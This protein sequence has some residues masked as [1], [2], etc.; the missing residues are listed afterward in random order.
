[1]TGEWIP[2]S[3]FYDKKE[4]TADMRYLRERLDKPETA[5]LQFLVPVDFHF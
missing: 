5:M 2:D 1:M 3:A 4:F